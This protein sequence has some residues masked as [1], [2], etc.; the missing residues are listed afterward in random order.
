MAET[1]YAAA[2]LVHRE[3]TDGSPNS[4]FVDIN[5]FSGLFMERFVGLRISKAWNAFMW[6]TNTQKQAEQSE[7]WFAVLWY[8]ASQSVTIFFLLA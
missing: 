5:I 3:N 7:S 8:G 1:C 4:T 2:S 6:S